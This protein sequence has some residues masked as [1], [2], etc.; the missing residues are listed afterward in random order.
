MSTHKTTERKPIVPTLS[1]ACSLVLCLTQLVSAADAVSFKTTIAPILLDNCLACHSAKKAEGGYRVDSY[2]ELLKAGDTGEVP[3]ALVPDQPSELL[4]RLTC[5]DASERMPAESD[6]L[7]AEQI[8]LVKTWI[9]QGAKF[10]G[11]EPTQSLLFVIPPSTYPAPPDVYSHSIPVAAT[12]F[13]PDG[14]QVIAGGYHELTVWNSTTGQLVRRIP[15]LAQRIYALD[16]SPDGKLLAVGSGEPGRSGEVRL[17][18]FQTGDIRA[19]VARAQDV[20]L[21]VAFSPVTNQLAVAAADSLIR[22]V[23]TDT[24]QEVRTLASHADWVHALAWSADGKRLIS[25]SRDKSAK[26]YDAL[27]GE[28]LASYVGHGA[29]VRGVAFVGDAQQAVSCGAD[30]KLH[31]WAVEGPKKVAE[32]ALGGE[33]HKLIVA[34]NS[35]FVPCADKRVVRVDLATNKISQVYDGLDAWVVSAALQ[36]ISGS[37]DPANPA[38]VAGGL[39]GE[40]RVWKTGDA[41]LVHSWLAKP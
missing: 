39:N 23:D 35:L 33:G 3:V 15:N 9:E 22:L 31:R 8:E 28:L 18:D 36:P 14:T 40:L 13:S 37:D 17:V 41:T 19:T 7:P 29:A 26:V 6:P 21:D 34:E 2:A 24:L 1:V 5:P 4:R 11:Q 32:V 25:G 38:L 12:I 30:N 16:F 27:T 20:V 10:D